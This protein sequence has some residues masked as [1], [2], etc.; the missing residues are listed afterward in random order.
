MAEFSFNSEVVARC[1][2]RRERVPMTKLPLSLPPNVYQQMLM[3]QVMPA[4]RLHR[5]SFCMQIL[6]EPALD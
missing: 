4:R 3:S 1:A 5:P 6:R 2:N